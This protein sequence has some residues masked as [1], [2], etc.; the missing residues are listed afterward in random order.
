MGIESPNR[1]ENITPDT[2]REV[3]TVNEFKLQIHVMNYWNEQNGLGLSHNDL[4]KKWIQSG[5][6]AK[7][8]RFKELYPDHLV[9]ITNTTSLAE[10]L[11]RIS[12]TATDTL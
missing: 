5:M 8:G 6:S 1:L 12:N 9:D 3:Y 7:Y 2:Q 4:V 11:D 10:V